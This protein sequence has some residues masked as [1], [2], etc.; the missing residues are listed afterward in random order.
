[1]NLFELISKVFESNAALATIISGIVAA[2]PVIL[3]WLRKSR[4][5]LWEAIEI[6]DAL[7]ETAEFYD[8]IIKA[9]DPSSKGGV[10]FTKEEIEQIKA[11]GMEAKEAI[12][13]SAIGDLLKKLKK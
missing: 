2:F 1:M 6:I 8:E 3:V 7:K 13:K 11:A 10:K 12:E 9:A 4:K 5:Y